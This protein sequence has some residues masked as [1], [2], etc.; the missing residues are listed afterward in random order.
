L[1]VQYVEPDFLDSIDAFPKAKAKKIR[2]YIK[3]LVGHM[4]QSETIDDLRH[5]N[6]SNVALSAQPHLHLLAGR[7]T[8][9]HFPKMDVYLFTFDQFRVFFCLRGQVCTLLRAEDSG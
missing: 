1:I 4:E 3:A 7:Q 6:L 5:I 2:V 9:Q 8:E